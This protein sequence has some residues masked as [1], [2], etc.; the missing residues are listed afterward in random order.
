MSKILITGAA[1]FVGF[2]LAKR[3]SKGNNELVLVDNLS[4]GRMDD[5]YSELIT[6]GKIKFI[7]ADI[8]DRDFFAS[9][10]DDF[11]YIYHLA[12][13]LGVKNVIREPEKVLYVNAL[14]T[15]NLLEW[16]KLKEIKRVLFSS[17]SESYAGTMRAYGV[18]V[19]TPESISLNIDDIFSPRTTYALSKIFGESC[20]INYSRKYNIPFT[21][22]RFHN[23]YGPRMGYAHVIPELIIKTSKSKNTLDVFS[24]K[25]TRAFCYID[26]AINAI[27]LCAGKENTVGEVIN[28]GNSTEEIEIGDLASMIIKTIGKDLVINPLE[29]T[30]G[31]PDRRC[32]DISKLVNLTGFDPKISLVEGIGLTYNW[33][34]HKLGEKHE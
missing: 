13:V 19:P 17:T 15:L 23:I 20:F 6:R 10:K 33:Y 16:I 28:V 32:P 3:L 9:L 24:V 8:T 29:N 7:N 2:H 27:L 1:G 34:K 30:P 22:F 4:R 18:P 14:S 5:D 26:D 21:I 11:N 12:A 25:Q 31:S